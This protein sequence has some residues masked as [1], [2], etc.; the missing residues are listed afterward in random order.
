MVTRTPFWRLLAAVPFLVLFFPEP[1]ACQE[2]RGTS[3]RDESTRFDYSRSHSF[4]RGFY[5]YT[6]PSLA[7]P[8]L[9]N[10]PRLQDLIVG[11]KLTLKLDDAIALALG[12]LGFVPLA[13]AAGLRARSRQPAFDKMRACYDRLQACGGI[14]MSEEVSD[15]T[16]WQAHLP[17][18]AHT[19]RAFGN[20]IRGSH[21]RLAVVDDFLD[22]LLFLALAFHPCFMFKH[23]VE[24]GLRTLDFR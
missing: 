14:L 18:E 11:G 9:A 1:A 10:S 12:M 19:D 17:E 4:P 5:P 20:D 8:R 7:G 3:V 15:M 24:R 2:A 6:V 23:F 16:A 22:V 13:M 21:E